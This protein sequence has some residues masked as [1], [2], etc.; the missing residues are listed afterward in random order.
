MDHR[1][2]RPPDLPA[3]QYAVLDHPRMLGLGPAL[4]R[5]EL[6]MADVNVR[7]EALAAVRLLP[8][9]QVDQVQ[10]A[11][12]ADTE[13]PVAQPGHDHLVPRRSQ[14][15]DQRLPRAVGEHLRMTPP[16]RRCR[17]QR[18]GRKLPG[19]VPEEHP[20]PVGPGRQ[21]LAVQLVRQLLVSSLRSLELIEALQAR[22][23]AVQRA[24]RVRFLA[25]PP[26]P[27]V[28]PGVLRADGR[29]VPAEVPHRRSPLTGFR[30]PATAGDPPAGTHTPG[31][32]RRCRSAGTL[33]PAG[34]PRRP[35]A[36][37]CMRPGPTGTPPPAPA[38]PR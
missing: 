5:I 31:P 28:R 4:V 3:T 17:A 1:R 29:H 25:R 35:G 23:R 21:P 22:G 10:P 38:N 15:A 16:H 9:M 6:P 36:G 12:L 32:S 11:Q 13:P 27:A 37:S 24:L 18:V 8:Q 20:P 14:V 34:A 19:H 30:T 26:W 33:R 2:A 7:R